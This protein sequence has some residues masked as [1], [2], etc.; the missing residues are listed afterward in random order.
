MEIS[1]S[2]KFAV[3]LPRSASPRTADMEARFSGWMKFSTRFLPNVSF[4]CG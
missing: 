1:G 2:S 4:G 3:P